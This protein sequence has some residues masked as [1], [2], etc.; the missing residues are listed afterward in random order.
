MTRKIAAL[1]LLSGLMACESKKQPEANPDLLNP[2]K[3]NVLGTVDERYQSFNVEMLEITGGKFWKP[4]G[5]ELESLLSQPNKKISDGGDTP[6]GMNPGLYEYRSP[7]DLKKRRL[8]K[9]ARALGP[10]YMRVSGTW[11][12]S[13]YF[14]KPGEKLTNPPKGF[15]SILTRDQWKNVINFSKESNA[16]IVTSL[17]TS[18]GTRDE[19]GVWTTA[20]AKRLFDFTKAQGGHIAALE[21]MNEPN[22]PIMGGAP[23]GYNAKD[24]GKDFKIFADF[25]KKTSHDTI[26]LGPGSVG[27]SNHPNGDFVYSSDSKLI[28][29]ESLLKEIGG[30]NIQ[31]FSFHY[32]GALSKRCSSAGNQ[33]SQENSLSEDWLGRIDQTISFY[34]ALRDKYIPRVPLWNTETADAA[35][36]G[37]PWGGSFLDT[38]RYLDQLG[39]QA[40]QGVKVSIHN[41]LAASNYSLL[42]EKDFSPKPIFWGGLLWRRLMGSAV[43]DSEQSIQ[44]GLHVYAHCLYK[45]PG[46]VAMLVINNDKENSTELNITL[47]GRSYTLT[48]DSLPGNHIKLNGKVLKLATNDRLPKISGIPFNA[49]LVTF[50]PT[51]ITFLTFPEAKNP[52]CLQQ[53]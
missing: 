30:S 13:T 26:I 39:R 41:T 52:S 33:I 42:D 9:M 44:P 18:M 36:G 11:A 28:K 10:S 19:D 6:T 20:Q 53:E 40:T 16:R 45:T 21:F 34:A 15:M 22:L 23:L 37:N 47:N 1:L 17:A 5:A 49:G 27:E 51:T 35:C 32:Y 24:Y 43:L 2:G 25:V 12:N 8:L 31:A 14:Q 48:A 29:T 50:K 38:F 4:Y 7:M 46:G 3:L